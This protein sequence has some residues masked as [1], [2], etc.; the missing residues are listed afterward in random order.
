MLR[1]RGIWLFCLLALLLLA[2]LVSCE[3]GDVPGQALKEEVGDVCLAMRVG[4]I[5]QTKA[6][7]SAIAEM[8]SAG[9][10][11]RGLDKVYVIPFSGTDVIPGSE[12]LSLPLEL[13]G[14]LPAGEAY[15]ANAHLYKMHQAIPKG[16]ER[17]LA[18]GK[19]LTQEQ[20]TPVKIKQIY[21]S[22]VES[23]LNSVTADGFRFSPEAMYPST[24]D[25]PQAALVIADALTTIV[26]GSSYTTT[27]YYGTGGESKEITVA[28]GGDLRDSN[29]SDC[30]QQLT[31]DGR[32]LPG[33][34]AGVSVLLTTLYKALKLESIDEV[35]YQLEIDGVTYDAT[36]K[37]DE[38]ESPLLYKD[39]FNGLRQEILSKMHA[40][41]TGNNPVLDI[42]ET[43]KTVAF[44]D[45][46]VQGYPEN[47][48]L[49][50]GAATVR[51][52]PTGYVV[53][54]QNGL[55]GIAA[56]SD[57]CF[58]PA[59]Y[60]RAN[61]SVKTSNDEL[62][63]TAETAIN[64]STDWLGVLS[65]Y[66]LSGAKVTNLTA[67]M[68]LEDP[69]N[70]AVGMLAATVQADKEDLL[71]N[72][73]HTQVHLTDGLFPLTGIIIGRQYPQYFDFTPVYDPSA[74]PEPRQ[75]YLYDNQISG[76]SLT[77]TKSSEFRTLVLQTPKEKS[78]Y[79]CLEFLNN[80]SNITFYGIDEGRIMPGHH[81]YLV[82]LL[83]VPSEKQKDENENELDSVFIQDRITSVNFTIKSLENAYSAIPDMGI[84]QLSIG[85]LAQL[86]WEMATP[87]E[88]WLD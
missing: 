27:A 80:S 33:S 45:Q 9:A 23:G 58:P 50:S 88:I 65:T 30:Y 55:D 29:L 14:F 59:L 73:Y 49:P 37:V 83:E 85:V 38:V 22:L 84:P 2:G 52:S 61:T 21:G 39:L 79:V 74:S 71:D 43:D 5:S 76:I 26:N 53:P 13:P 47:L 56:L 72:N 17:V 34:G 11:F 31:A 42:N 35:Q 18:Y 48:G 68:A 4:A 32:L 36:K 8:N 1:L 28:W 77:A 3:R 12:P 86:N 44:H 66:Y 20:S 46:G 25:R 54:L 16:T 69:L 78:V 75:Y 10:S 64:Q 40:L 67:S 63:E 57:Y 81:F 51:W 62:D 6:D 41:S 82:G 15:I 24:T 87:T 19:G 7:V 70:F 60:Y